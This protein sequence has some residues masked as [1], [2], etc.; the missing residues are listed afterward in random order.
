M[1]RTTKNLS[2]CFFKTFISLAPIGL[3]WGCASAPTPHNVWHNEVQEPEIYQA[4]NEHPHEHSNEYFSQKR[5]AQQHLA[6]QH[7]QP[8]PT[9]HAPAAQAAPVQQDCWVAEDGQLWCWEPEVAAPPPS[10]AP[11]RSAPKK[12][13]PKKTYI[14]SLPAGPQIDRAISMFQHARKAYGSGARARTKRRMGWRDFLDN[15]D[16]AC[17]KEPST[18]DMGAFIRARVTIEAEL[19][20]DERYN[21][22]MD[23][24][25]AKRARD[26]IHF[27]HSRVHELRMAA[28]QLDVPHAPN[29]YKGKPIVLR[30][31]LRSLRI[32]SKF[33]PRRDPLDGRRRFHAGVDFGAPYGE[34]IRAAAF[35]TIVFADKLGGHG[36]HVV[37]DHGNGYKTHYS[38]LERIIAKTGQMVETGDVVGLVGSTGRSTGP[39]LHFAVTNRYGSYLDPIKHLNIPLPDS[40]DDG[41]SF[42]GGPK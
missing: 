5:P 35:G 11:I 7:Y 29:P 31:P 1:A 17:E 10:S 2:N 8:P 42:T 21:R 37:V 13:P 12:A 39:H 4:E 23:E 33:G 20:M 30:D 41:F 38:H 14:Q 26:S 34:R 15:V 19:E 3:L 22:I 40:D 27:V 28:F 6:D 18:A 32:T 25:I 16:L 9:S 24:A 36:L